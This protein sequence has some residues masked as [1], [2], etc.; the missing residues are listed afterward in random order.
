M[1]SREDGSIRSYSERKADLRT[2]SIAGCAETALVAV[3]D[4]VSNAR[5]MR[6]GE[7]APKQRK[8]AHYEATLALVSGA[9]PD[10]PLLDLLGKEL[11]ML[12]AGR[13]HAHA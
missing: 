9:Y 11:R 3:A 7:K 8:V 1:G 6:R 5:R 4:K 2:R 13:V 10:L 12:R